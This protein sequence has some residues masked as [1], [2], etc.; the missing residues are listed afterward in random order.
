MLPLGTCSD[1]RFRVRGVIDRGGAC[2]LVLLRSLRSLDRAVKYPPEVFPH[3]GHR[4]EQLVTMPRT[5]HVLLQEL[6]VRLFINV[7]FL[8]ARLLT[9]QWEAR[10]NP[11]TH[12]RKPRRFDVGAEPRQHLIKVYEETQR[13]VE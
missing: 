7:R 9:N 5:C 2:S 4:F 3:F 1:L 13:G 10:S 8:L 6:L 11:S 12:H